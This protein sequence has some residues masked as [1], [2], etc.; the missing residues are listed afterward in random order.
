[1]AKVSAVMNAHRRQL[2]LY[3]WL[4]VS[5]LFW[6]ALACG[7]W[8]VAVIRNSFSPPPGSGSLPA[9]GIRFFISSISIYALFS[10]PAAFLL[11][12]ADKI[13]AKIPRETD[14]LDVGSAG[15]EW[16]LLFGWGLL[17]FKWISNLLPF[18][19]EGDHLPH[20]P[21][22][23]ILPLLGLH[24]WLNRFFCGSKH[25][26]RIQWIMIVFGA[27]FLSK[28]SYQVFIHSSLSIFTRG[29]LFLV[30]ASA[31]FFAANVF[32]S[33]LRRIF[34]QKLHP[35]PAPV[36]LFLTLL[37]GGLLITFNAM[38][39]R[40]CA[41]PLPPEGGASQTPGDAAKKNVI[42]VVVDCLRADHLGCYG[43][44]RKTSPFLDAISGSGVLFEQ[45]IAPSSWTIPSVVSLFTGMY[46]QQHQVNEPGTIIPEGIVSLQERLKTR[47]VS[48]AA[49]ITNNYLEGQW[50]Y[51][52]GFDHYFE[53]YLK[54]EFKEYVASQLFF[55][56]ALLF[57]KS[58]F[59]YP[60]S[61]DPGGARWWSQG[62]PPFNHERIS[63]KKVTDDVLTWIN[64]HARSPFYLYVHYMDV[65]SPYDTVWYPLFD[66]TEYD[67]QSEKEKLTNI[68]DGR[69]V[70]VDRQLERIWNE[71]E[72]LQL[73]ENTLVVITADHGEE[74]YDHGGIGHCT[75]LYDEL[76][77]VPLIMYGP[78]LPLRVARITRQVQLIDLP[79]T[80]LDYLEM[81]IPEQ[82]EGESLLH[83]M[84][85]SPNGVNPPYALSYTTRG[86]KNLETEEGRALWEKKVWDHGVTLESLRVDGEWKL[87]VGD[88]GQKELY[89]LRKDSS[90]QQNVAA[91]DRVSCRQMEK[92]LEEIT[93]SM[94][95]PISEK[96]TQELS[97]ETREQLR[98][99][100]YL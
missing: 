25:C 42:V 27:V 5:L 29:G 19:T 70:Y 52:R 71:L 32:H 21:Y 86:R 88:D 31:A 1:M 9:V 77:R 57:F 92:I 85:G 91:T 61:V 56:N 68:Y 74:L 20:T 89:N 18:L 17:W 35:R 40:Q 7:E 23:L 90:E 63:A 12:G 72:R 36:I 28:T 33:C 81:K 65:H 41:F 4:V 66:S 97:P 48:T 59:F 51:A 10:I 100:G 30:F 37:A 82:M 87:I 83:V 60:Y 34:L 47:G 44:H 2:S 13:E 11:F 22:V 45:C 93:S 14:G 69:I 54:R 67:S 80:I 55:L 64:T 53:C 75:T 94:E 38:Y 98:A 26:H 15:M 49:F 99:L 95:T 6:L 73:S 76:V 8:L 24:L 96:K 46:P 62:F 16:C 78:S 39:A 79:V 50:G 84:T 43:Y 58:E 3:E